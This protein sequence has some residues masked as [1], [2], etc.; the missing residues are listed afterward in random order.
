MLIFV[1]MLGSPD[2]WESFLHYLDCLLEDDS[3]WCKGK[4]GDQT[5]WSNIVDT[6]ACN[7][8]HL[9]DEVVHSYA[10]RF[11]SNYRDPETQQMYSVLRWT[12]CPWGLVCWSKLQILCA[13]SWERDAP[14]SSS[15]WKFHNLVL[16]IYRFTVKNILH[17]FQKMAK[18]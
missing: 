1:L 17:R 2:D 5:Q 16:V 4:V 7:L 15:I 8:S 9:T 18:D 3:R 13:S 6:S 14:K 11:L 12:I 10:Y